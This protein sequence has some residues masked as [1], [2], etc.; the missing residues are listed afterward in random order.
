MIA[1]CHACNGKISEVSVKRADLRV[2]KCIS[3]E[4]HFGDL[5]EDVVISTDQDFYPAIDSTYVEQLSVARRI[6]PKRIKKYVTL[7]RRPMKSI[8]E[9]GCA[10][11]AYARAFEELGEASRVFR[12]LDL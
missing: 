6:L 11:G 5:N 8:I 3:C 4:L 7:L 12:R 9:V 2:F 10:T 1:Q